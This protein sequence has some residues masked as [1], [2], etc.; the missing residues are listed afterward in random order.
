MNGNSRSAARAVSHFVQLSNLNVH[1]TSLSEQ[2]PGA[3][4]AAFGA[5]PELLPELLAGKTVTIAQL[6]AIAPAGVS[7]PSCYLYQEA[8]FALAGM[9]FIGCAGNIL[10]LRA[11]PF[12]GASKS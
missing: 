9:S 8:L 11:G 5:A 6:M 7:D 4:E 1:V 3:F 12:A 2:S 10:A